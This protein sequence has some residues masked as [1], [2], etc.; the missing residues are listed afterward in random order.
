MPTAQPWY[1]QIQALNQGPDYE[2]WA[3]VVPSEASDLA[4]F[5]AHYLPPNFS[6][7]PA[8]LLR[9]GCT[10]Y[11]QYVDQHTYDKLQAQAKG[12]DA[13]VWLAAL[14]EVC[15]HTLS[16]RNLLG[17]NDYGETPL[18]I[19]LAKSQTVNLQ[20]WRVSYSGDGYQGGTMAQGDDARSLLAY[21]QQQD[22]ASQA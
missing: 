10:R 14:I 19:H 15:D 5:I 7:N 3:A 12:D 13:P 8:A 4:D 2:F 6:K 18:L 1:W 9:P 21:L 17:G 20:Q 11:A 16:I 22:C